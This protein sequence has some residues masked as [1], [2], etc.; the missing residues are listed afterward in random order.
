[1]KRQGYCIF[2]TLLLSLTTLFSQSERRWRMPYADHN[3]F[4]LGLVLGIEGQGISLHNREGY[5]YSGEP[6]LAE[7]GVYKPGL[8]IGITGGLVIRPN[9][10][11]RL[12]PTL[13]IGEM[14]VR[15]SNGQK[16]VENLKLKHSSID[17]PLQLKWAS[18]RSV[19]IRPYMAVGPYLS[20]RLAGTNEMSL[21]RQSK[22]GFGLLY[23]LGC[24]FYLGWVKLSP[25]L[26]YGLSLGNRLILER[27]E[28]SGD[29]RRRYS[30]ALTKSRSH[31]ISLSLHIQ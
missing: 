28:F 16:S 14:N 13:H 22:V 10:E 12:M 9:L 30:D 8:A 19:N 17:L 24:D 31:Y 2:A 7:Q 11:L 26:S 15:Y 25:E 4:Y 5:T 18:N 29:I 6:L 23:S 21:L 20:Y 27:P 3:R 1:M